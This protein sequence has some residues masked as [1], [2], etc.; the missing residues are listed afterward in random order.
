MFPDNREPNKKTRNAV[1]SHKSYL[2]ISPYIH[3]H[4][5]YIYTHIYIYRPP[6]YGRRSSPSSQPVLSQFSAPGNEPSA[7]PHLAVSSEGLLPLHR[8]GVTG[9]WLGCWGRM[10]D[11]WRW[12]Q[13][14]L[15]DMTS[16]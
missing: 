3:T 11:D 14:D 15:W 5:L 8:G 16:I 4:I 2:I 12:G 7:S 9:R 6:F 13:L 1:I 10:T